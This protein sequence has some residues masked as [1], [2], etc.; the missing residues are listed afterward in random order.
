MNRYI[1]S[2]NLKRSLTKFNSQKPFP[3]T[4]VDNFFKASIA[5]RLEKEFPKYDSK[6]LHTYNNYC[7]IKKSSN[8]WNFFPALTYE[9]FTI[10]NSNEIIK[11]ICKKLKIKK[12]FPD[13]GLNG[14]GW[15]MMG[16]KGRLNPHLDYSL[17]PKVRGQ[18]KFN[19]IIFLT[20]NW[21]NKYGGETCFFS[22]SKNFIYY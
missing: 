19:L 14:G 9:I 1:N 10:L 12:L 7:E 6:S 13:Y 5:K 4:I 22:K 8:N 20:K 15:H 18:R 21:K 17:H 11:L 3:Y 16:D 2:N